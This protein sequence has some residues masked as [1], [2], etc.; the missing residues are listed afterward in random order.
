MALRT[1]RLSISPEDTPDVRRVLDLDGRSSLATLHVEIGRAFEL[2]PSKALYAF[3]LSGRFWDSATAYVDP[4]VEGRR[5][6]KALLFRSSLQAGATFAYLLG[7][8]VERHYLVQ[9]LAI[10]EVE[11]ALAAPVLVESVGEAS[12]EPPPPEPSALEQE[13]PELTVLVKLAE[14]FL[15]LDDQLDP[16]ADQLAAA[17]ALSEPW[18]ADD[19][20]LG[21][22]EAF[23]SGQRK[24]ELEGMAEAVPIFSSAATAAERLLEALAGSVQSFLQLDEWLLAR[25]LGTRLLDLPMSLSLVGDVERALSLSRAMAFIDPELLHGDIAIILARAGRREEALAQVDENLD[26]ARDAALVEAKA[27]DVYR[28]LGDVPAAE[29]YYRRSLTV[30]KT[31][32]DR[33]HALLRIVACLT[34]SGRDAEASELLQQARKE[35]GEPEPKTV[36]GRNEPCPCGSGKKY[37]KCHGA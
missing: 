11:Q 24:P 6:D 10:T 7:F 27:G 2:P 8:E 16:F 19:A 4:R 35:R 22:L 9:V 3:F 18:E 34:D 30:A 29:A 28:A 31:S 23:K 20:A 5:A 17:R 15:D 32:S 14:A 36:V 25:A 21:G 33:L 37:K 12:L 13:P 1:Y 26:R